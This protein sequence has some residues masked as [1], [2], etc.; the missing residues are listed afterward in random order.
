MSPLDAKKR[1]VREKWMCLI[2]A[3]GLG[4]IRDMN[5]R[6]RCR[7]AMKATISVD[8]FVKKSRDNCRK[9]RQDAVCDTLM[10]LLAIKKSMKSITCT[11]ESAFAAITCLL[12]PESSRC[13]VFKP[14]GTLK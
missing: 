4:L 9:A 10:I 1:Q 6:F 12:A 13:G 7:S 5:Q 2:M 8:N 11:K 3:Q 14:L